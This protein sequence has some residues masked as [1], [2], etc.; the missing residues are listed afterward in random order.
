MSLK[1]SGQKGL[2]GQE[3][4]TVPDSFVVSNLLFEA[5]KPKCV[6]RSHEPSETLFNQGED[7]RGVYLVLS[8]EVALS[9]LT[10]SGRVLTG[11]RTAPGFVLG[12]PAVVGNMP[13]TLTAEVQES[14]VIGFV[15][16]EAFHALLRIEQSICLAVLNILASEVRAARGVLRDVFDDGFERAR[17]SQLTVRVALGST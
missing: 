6:I 17:L 16:C 8:G 12:I 14:S 13:Y 10:P 7:P 2:L 9:M 15:S 3:A 5:L 11:I 4:M 1:P